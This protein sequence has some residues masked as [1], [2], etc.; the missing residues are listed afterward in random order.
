MLIERMT[1]AQAEDLMRHCL[2]EGTIRFGAHCRDKQEQLR[3]S[4][5]DLRAVLRRGH[6]YDPPEPDIKT[7]EWKY[8]FE[9][10][11]LEGRHLILAASFKT[12]DRAFL[13][14][15]FEKGG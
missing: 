6:V 3:I 11:D 15:V 10:C 1:P 2:E 4:D 7:G 14:T 12:I 13:I 9:G 8:R 5:E